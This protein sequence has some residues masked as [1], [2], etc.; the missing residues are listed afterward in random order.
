MGWKHFNI[1][2]ADDIKGEAP[3]VWNAQNTF[4][5][6]HGVIIGS[7]TAGPA[8]LVPAYLKDI[9]AFYKDR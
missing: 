2:P 8:G 3:I 1:G 6:L 9:D 4:F 5:V 7:P